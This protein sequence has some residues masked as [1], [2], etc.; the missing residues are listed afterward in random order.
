M[1]ATLEADRRPPV[2]LFTPLVPRREDFGVPLRS[3]RKRDLPDISP[4]ANRGRG[5]SVAEFRVGETEPVR[6]KGADGWE[7]HGLIIRPEA[8]DFRGPHPMITM[9]HGGPTGSWSPGYN[10][11]ADWSGVLERGIAVFLPNPRG[12]TGRGLEF[13]ESNIGD[14]GGKDWEDILAGVEHCVSEGIADPDRLGIGGGSYGGYMTAWA[15]TQTDRFKAAVMR[16]GISDW[17]SFHGRS[18][19]AGWESIHY[20]DAD[21]YDPDG[22]YRKFSPIAHLKRVKTPTLIIH[23]E[24]DSRLSCGTGLPLSPSIKG[25]GGG[26]GAGDL[27]QGGPRY[28]RARPQAR[29]EAPY[30]AVVRGPASPVPRV[31]TASGLS[32]FDLR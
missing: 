22:A 9:V 27:P 32:M 12:S 11:G 15:V 5:P 17:R 20:V 14:M 23:G 10:L 31:S 6:W 2:R 25:P 3:R 26:N 18:T 1:V 28:Q 13:A 21:P 30:G 4:A 16:A 8:S 19:I 7:V 29:P 24:L